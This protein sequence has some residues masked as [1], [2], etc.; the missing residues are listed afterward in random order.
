VLN[1]T[2]IYSLP[3]PIKEP[4]TRTIVANSMW[5]MDFMQDSLVSVAKF[6]KFNVIDDFN[7][8]ALNIDIDVTKLKKD[9]QRA[10]KLIEWRG[11]PERMR[12]D[13][14]PEFTSTPS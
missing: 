2:G 13:N 8:D 5:S 14:G 11:K 4:L 1:Y 7:R 6:R 12:M 9:C 10:D 3:V